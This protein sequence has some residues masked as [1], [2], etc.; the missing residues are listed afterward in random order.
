L[1][2]FDATGRQV[3][4]IEWLYKTSLAPA[5]HRIAVQPRHHGVEQYNVREKAFRDSDGFDASCAVCTSSFGAL[6]IF[7][8]DSAAFGQS[9]TTK[10]CRKILPVQPA[11]IGSAVNHGCV[12]S[13]TH[14]FIEYF[15]AIGHEVG[16]ARS[17]YPSIWP[18]SAIRL[19]LLSFDETILGSHT[20]SKNSCKTSQSRGKVRHQ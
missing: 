5:G 3:A 18:I 12:S 6:A 19:W 13:K 2:D 8:T 20:Q 11:F 16:A 17:A 4:Q 15:D 10:T 1:L 7:A 9:S 14:G